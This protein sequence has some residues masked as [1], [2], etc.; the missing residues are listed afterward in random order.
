MNLLIKLLLIT[1]AFTSAFA[2]SS[3]LPIPVIINLLILI[4]SIFRSIDTKEKP[5]FNQLD[6]FPIALLLSLYLSLIININNIDTKAINHTLAYTFCIT[7]L[8][9]F[10]ALIL[11][12]FKFNI[13]KYVTIGF[14]IAT[15]FTIIEFININLLKFNI[16]NIIPRPTVSTYEP[17]F[18]G[19]I[20]RA[21]SFF[22]ESGYLGAFVATIS[23][24]AF[25]YSIQKKN[26][27]LKLFIVILTL[28]NIV[29]SFSISLWLFLP[30]SILTGSLLKK[31]KKKSFIIDFL[32]VFVFCSFLVLIFWH[33][34][35]FVYNE[36]ISKF[37]SF[38]FDDRLSKASDNLGI[39]KNSNIIHLLFGYGPGSYEYLKVQPA[40]SFYLNLFR[41][42]G[43]L[44][45][46]IFFVW[47]FF[48][49]YESISSKTIFSYYYLIS[50]LALLFFLIATPNYFYSFI[51]LIFILG[52]S[53][54]K[55]HQN[56][57]TYYN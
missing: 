31:A 51:W 16:N 15:V 50:L 4:F 10:N 57:F 24:L 47:I 45:L 29:L 37:N 5:N 8:Y 46:S 19:I 42:S 2:I 12:G 9:L 44:G 7:I 21:R 40:I 53:F 56:E 54:L 28:F 18:Y 41:D 1:L 20:I 30:I 17:T 26:R 32:K 39:I 34:F 11:R 23:P 14:I 3:W 52:T 13:L 27:K 6:I 33:Y 38:S 25:Y 36:I 43:I 49:I 35:H 22:E 48:I 55:N